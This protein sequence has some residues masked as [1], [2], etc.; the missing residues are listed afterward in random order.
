[1]LFIS[2]SQCSVQSA[3]VAQQEDGTVLNAVEQKQHLQGCPAP[4]SELAGVCGCC[5]FTYFALTTGDPECWVLSLGRAWHRHSGALQ[6]RLHFGLHVT[7]SGL[8]CKVGFP[9]KALTLCP[10]SSPVPAS[11]WCR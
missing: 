4:A 5:Q 9:G 6:C 8:R 2:V 11:I 1:M 7:T 3:F 10:A